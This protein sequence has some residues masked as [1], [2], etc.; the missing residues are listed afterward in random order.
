MQSGDTVIKHLAEIAN[1]QR[2]GEYG[3][4]YEDA[5]R[6]L[7]LCEENSIDPEIRCRLLIAAARSSY[8][9]SRFDECVSLLAAADALLDEKIPSERG[10]RFESAIVRANVCRREGKLRDALAALE[11]YNGVDAP[12]YQHSLIPEK[13]LIEGACYLY[14]NNMERAEESLETA[15]GLATHHS[16]ARMRARVLIMLGLVAQVRGLHEA[17]A[18]YFERAKDLCS[19]TADYYGEAAAALDMGILQ[20]RRGRFSNAERN[21]ERARAIFE[22]IEWRLGVCR[23][24]LALGNISKCRGEYVSAIRS[25]REAG[26]IA[27]SS[28]YARE[29]ALAAEF[30][31]DVHYERGRYSSAEK[32]Y[33]D[34]LHIAG[35]IA[36]EGDIVVEITRRMGELSLAKEDVDAALVLL[37]KGLRLSQKLGDKL[38]KGVILKAMGRAALMRGARDRGI[39]LFISALRTLHEAGCDFELGKTH[40]AFAELL[41]DN[42][43]MPCGEPAGN[44]CP[45]EGVLDEAWR[46]AVEAS[47]LFG[48]M[49]IESWKAAAEHCIKRVVARRRERFH[50]DPVL[51]GGRR[52]VKIDF[53]PDFVHAQ[54]FVAV[55]ASTLKLCEQSRFAAEF[56]RPVLITGETGTGKECVARMIHLSSRRARR[57]FV[58]LNCAAVPDHL[59]ESEFF[60]HKKGC[61]TG[62]L[63]DRVGFFEEANGGTLLL[64]EIGEL[65]PLQQVKLLRVLQEGKIRRVG[66]N[67][68]HP[69]D[70]RIISATNQDLEEKLGKATFREDFFYR[71]NAEHI[72]VPALRERQEDIIP[73]ISY[74]HWAKNGNGPRVVRIELAALQCLQRHSWPGNIRELFAVLDRVR[75]I[76]NGDV[77]TFDMLPER[78]RAQC[79]ASRAPT[80]RRGSEPASDL[81]QRLR[82]ALESCEGNKSAAARRLGISRGTLYKELRRSGL[83]K[84]TSISPNSLKISPSSANP[85]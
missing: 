76:A 75:H 37:R 64:D 78:M 85:D 35:Q 20:S 80:M 3:K 33:R 59:F 44:Q 42:G 31:G 9:V 63:T 26:R 53:S 46:S 77:I 83:L 12:E 28:G 27:S 67:T 30:I 50:V 29:N 58:A 2:Q 25:Y 84:M 17:A 72:H 4:S 52:I 38:E 13:L 60:G 71:I 70:V 69:V 19:A 23:C 61:F 1:L 8:Y 18:V 41:I 21:I 57:P 5:K 68:E 74:F 82:K 36:P 56:E 65:T 34:A 15:L 14:L 73:L 49:D 43:K 39:G 51:Q 6:L 79:R 66:E 7:A 32:S 54:G 24:I 62:A 10:I 16:D 47:H 55:S 40:L 48:G 11:P 81:G 45:T 22:R